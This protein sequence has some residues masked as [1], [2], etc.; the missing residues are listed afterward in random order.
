[1][2]TTERE[3]KHYTNKSGGKG[4]MHIE[5]ILTPEMMGDHM[6]M[7][8]KA[9]IDVNSSLGYHEHHG[10]SEAYYI[11]QGKALYND[12]GVERELCAG[13]LTFTPDGQGHSIENIGDEELIFMA[14]IIK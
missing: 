4:T 2:I 12:N 11:I 1:M 6:T 14:V 3:V 9:T 7:Y 5:H 13:A 8:A 10:D